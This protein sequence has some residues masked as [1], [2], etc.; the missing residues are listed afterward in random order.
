MNR[1]VKEALG[2]VCNLSRNYG[3]LTDSRRVI[4]VG[5]LGGFVKDSDRQHPEVWFADY[6]RQH[7]SSPICVAVYSNHERR[8]AVNQIVRLL[9]TDSDGTLSESE[10]EQARIIV[11]GHSWGASET[12]AFARD[13]GQRGIPVL[14]TIQLDIVPKPRQKPSVI[15]SNVEKAINFFQSEGFLRGQG[16]IVAADP[17][18]TRILGNVRMTYDE[19]PIDCGNFPWLARTFNKPHH[20]IENDRQVWNLIRDL[21]DA[22]LGGQAQA[23]LAPLSP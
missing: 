1:Q 17:T 8:A 21:I 11:Y 2:L 12:T 18:K 9:D 16:Q 5:F 13:L 19:H 6:L 10:K 20:E 7:Y 22:D 23:R 3:D 4:V 15:P 14:L